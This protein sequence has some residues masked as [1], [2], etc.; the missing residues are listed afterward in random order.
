MK[1][2]VFEAF[3]AEELLNH[4]KAK[5]DYIVIKG[6]YCEKVYDLMKSHLSETEMMGFELGSGG[7]T[8]ILA[9]IINNLRDFIKNDTDIDETTKAIEKK[10]R[11]YKVQSVCKDE[12]VLKLKQLEY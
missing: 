5:E 10:L 2:S 8:P 9:T 3:T 6:A 11:I 12:I 7:T 4:L 1:N